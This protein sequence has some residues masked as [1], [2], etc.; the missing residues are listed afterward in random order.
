MNADADFP[1]QV[2]NLINELGATTDERAVCT[3]WILIT[4]WTN[5]DG[6]VWLEEHRTVEM[7]AWRRLG[8]LWYVIEAPSIGVDGDDED[9]TA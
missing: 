6:Q 2:H 3:S 1:T 4:E 8:I 5:G 9:D 7:P